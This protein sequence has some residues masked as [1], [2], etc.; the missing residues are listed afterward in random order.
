MSWGTLFHNVE[1]VGKI[2]QGRKMQLSRQDKDLDQHTRM[3]SKYLRAFGHTALSLERVTAMGCVIAL[4]QVHHM[5]KACI[6][7]CWM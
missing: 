2:L 1:A 7:K 3:A 5:R 6:V 4:M